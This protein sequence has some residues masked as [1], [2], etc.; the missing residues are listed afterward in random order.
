MG[1]LVTDAEYATLD[2]G[3]EVLTALVHEAC[4]AQCRSAEEVVAQPWGMDPL[5]VQYAPITAH[6]LERSHRR[7]W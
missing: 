4:T 1:V 3:T 7:A 5:L 2:I 6:A